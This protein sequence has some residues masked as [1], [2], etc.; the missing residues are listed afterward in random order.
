MCHSV[1]KFV[2]NVDENGVI[3]EGAV[4]LFFEQI[5]DGCLE[6]LFDNLVTGGETKDFSACESRGK[7][8]SLAKHSLSV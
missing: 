6:I 3:A 8:E 4:I 2:Q 7:E 5:G 1:N